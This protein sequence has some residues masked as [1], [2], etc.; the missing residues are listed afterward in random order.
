MVRNIM[1]NYIIIL[2]IKGACLKLYTVQE[3]KINEVNHPI[4]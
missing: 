4:Y 2:L 3:M 1:K